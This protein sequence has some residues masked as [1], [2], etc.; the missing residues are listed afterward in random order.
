MRCTATVNSV[1]GASNANEGVKEAPRVRSP[2]QSNSQSLCWFLIRSPIDTG[3][4]P[5]V[6]GLPVVC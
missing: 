6:R 5:K 1:D 3:V 2:T 4:Q